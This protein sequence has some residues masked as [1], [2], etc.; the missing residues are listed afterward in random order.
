MKF[1]LSRLAEE[2]ITKVIYKLIIQIVQAIPFDLFQ[3]VLYLNCRYF[4]MLNEVDVDTK[5]VTDP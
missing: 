4:T 5:P 3:K 1:Y 2:E